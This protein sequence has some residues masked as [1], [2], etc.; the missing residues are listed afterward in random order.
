MFLFL[1]GRPGLGESETMYAIASGIY[2]G[3]GIVGALIAPILLLNFK[4]RTVIAIAPV[5]Q[6]FGSTLYGLSTN[7]WMVIAGRF[8][9]GTSDALVITSVMSYYTA[10]TRNQPDIRLKKRLMIAYSVVI[11]VSYVP[12]TGKE[13]HK[14]THINCI[15]WDHLL[16][17]LHKPYIYIYIYISPL[18]LILLVSQLFQSSVDQFRWFSWYQ[19]VQGSVLEML[20]IFLFQSHDPDNSLEHKTSCTRLNKQERKQSKSGGMN[21]NQV[22]WTCSTVI[23]SLLNYHYH[24]Y[25][26]CKYCMYN[27]HCPLVSSDIDEYI[28]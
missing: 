14:V 24:N 1:Q 13:A 23:V 26:Y 10:S 20:V 9:L 2:N 4:Y 12:F 7:G 5:I 15:A 19:V 16:C 17:A 21:S 6:I 27:R 18:G 3:G 25:K 22:T 8:L 11:S 28:F